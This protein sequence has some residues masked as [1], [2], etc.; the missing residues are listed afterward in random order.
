MA[1][2]DVN[3]LQ[4]S[5]D[6]ATA[7]FERR[8]G[9]P[10][11]W[12]VAAPGR[13]NLIGE[14]VDYNDGFVM[15][16]AI[17]RYCVIA[18]AEAHGDQARLYSAATDDEAK[19]SL[20]ALGATGSASAEALAAGHWSNYAIGVIALC[21]ERGL[22]SP[23]FLA[24]IQSGV[25]FGGGLSSSA[26]LEVATATLIEAMTGKTL[27][28]VDKA[29]LCQKAE[30]EF[31]GVPC[32]IMDQFASVMC[33]ADHVMLLDCR[34]QQIEHIPLVAPNI[35][36]LI[37][38]SNVKH[39]LS[40]GEYAKRRAQCESAA[41]KLGVSALRDATLSHLESQRERLNTVE[42]GRARHIISEIERTLQAAAA[43]KAG[44]WPGVGR[45]MYAGHDSLRD[46]Y[47]VSCR[48]LDLLVDLARELGAERG[49]IGSRMTGG[50]FGGCTVSLVETGKVND[51]AK[52]LAENYQTKTGIEA[53][54]LSSRPARGAHI[55]RTG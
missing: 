10:P 32:G 53:T 41:R 49:V 54:M 46:D 28:P 24:V 9:R 42:F 55:I 1:Q 20:A 43:I 15:P 8:Y 34:S 11:R 16:M 13:V 5:I 52:F 37:V 3:P 25:P 35:T 29:L 7:T 27:N 39:E 26:S 48:E 2:G 40:G 33:R 31:A 4:Q 47:E 21:A 17:D 44:D 22:R 45:L 38:N 19:F 23:G 12:I 50:G 6:N 51:V 14:H 30:H 18:A 36:V